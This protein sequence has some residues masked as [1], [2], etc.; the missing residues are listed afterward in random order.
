MMNSI[1]KVRN[2][3]QSYYVENKLELPIAENDHVILQTSKGLEFCKVVRQIDLN[4]TSELSDEVELIRQATENDVEQN[5]KNNNQK[6]YFA[7]VFNEASKAAGLEMR[8][9]DIHMLHNRDRVTFFYMSEGRIDFRELVKKLASVVKARVELRQVSDRERA[10]LVGGIGPCGYELCC[11]NFLQEFATVNV[12]MAK[13][14]Q[15]SFNLQ[16]VT[17]LCDRLL[18][19][20]KYEHDQY[21][22]MK[23]EIPDVN[24]KIILN[25]GRQAKVQTLQLISRY[26]TLR[27]EDQSIE[28]LD[29]E[30]FFEMYT[31]EK[32]LED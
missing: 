14:Q 20:L 23:K 5:E 15:L 25:D 32:K 1:L 13:I 11:S 3:Y 30:A 9:V 18:C 24:R 16:R 17:G 22:E 12:K 6:K 27:Y 26:I 7:Q 2:E 21:I 29:F 8:L 4:D 19:C 28:T 10:K 31:P